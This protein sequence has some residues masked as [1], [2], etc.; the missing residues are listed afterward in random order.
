MRYSIAAALLSLVGGAM[1]TGVRAQQQDSVI[2]ASVRDTTCADTTDT[3]GTTDTT[4]GPKRQPVR[5]RNSMDHNE[6]AA[7]RVDNIPLEGTGKGFIPIPGTAS[8]SLKAGV[9]KPKRKTTQ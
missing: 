1:P 9:C 5:P 4:R 3:T 7:P 6:V 8:D 2:A